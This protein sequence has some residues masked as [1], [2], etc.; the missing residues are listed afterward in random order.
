M[1]A[2]GSPERSISSTGATDS[3]QT[4]HM[5]PFAGHAA[6]CGGVIYAVNGQNPPKSWD[7]CRNAATMTKYF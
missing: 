7:F 6:T 2:T 3:S 5:G 4:G 1:G